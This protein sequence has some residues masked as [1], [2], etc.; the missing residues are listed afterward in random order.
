MLGKPHVVAIAAPIVAEDGSRLGDPVCQ[1]EVAKF[2]KWL[3][4]IHPARRH[5][6]KFD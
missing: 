1:V 5:I 4:A 2:W 3:S 6:L